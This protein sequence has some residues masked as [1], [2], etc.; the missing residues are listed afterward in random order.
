MGVKT[1]GQAMC[2]EFSHSNEILLWLIHFAESRFKS[3]LSASKT[4]S[5]PLWQRCW[6]GVGSSGGQPCVSGNE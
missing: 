5:N 3:L 2:L 1:A 6:S 4:T